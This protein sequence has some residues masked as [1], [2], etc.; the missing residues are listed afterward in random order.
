MDKK[1]HIKA[2]IKIRN[3]EVFGNIFKEKN[4]LEEQLEHIHEGWIQ[5][6][7]NQETMDKEKILMQD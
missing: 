5:G 7:I 1:K 2:K 3:H 6:K 4:K